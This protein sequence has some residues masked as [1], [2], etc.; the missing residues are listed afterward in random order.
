M[1]TL[2][3]LS[4]YGRKSKRRRCTVAA[5][6]GAPQKKGVVVKMGITTPRK[7]NSAKRKYAKVRMIV[8]KKV[9]FA[10]VPGIGKHGLQE[11][12]IVLVEGGNPPDV[13][14]VNYTLI[15]GVYDF[16]KL[17]EYARKKRR[18]KFGTPR[19]LKLV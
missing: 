19:P 18:S 1:P 14:G 7:P 12:S 8:A 15:R 4:F 3:Q 17:E 6:V 2:R 5:L 10:H 16:D 11:Y 9:I 13:P